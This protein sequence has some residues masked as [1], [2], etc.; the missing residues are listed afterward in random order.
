MIVY[1][2]DDIYINAMVGVT[3][4]IS[5]ISII[6]AIIIIS[7]TLYFGGRKSAML[8]NET[9]TKKDEYDVEVRIS[10]PNTYNS[11]D[12]DGAESSKLSEN[13]LSSMTTISIGYN[14]KIPTGFIFHENEVNSLGAYVYNKRLN[15]YKANLYSMYMGFRPAE[16]TAYHLFSAGEGCEMSLSDGL[17]AAYDNDECSYGIMSIDEKKID[18]YSNVATVTLMDCDSSIGYIYKN[19]KPAPAIDFIRRYNRRANIDGNLL[20]AQSGS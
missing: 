18:F 13:I 1:G 19:N 8:Q 6:V 5:V 2:Y 9:T 3:V 11:E 4:C 14:K 12:W 7:H 20:N 15:N 10:P 16:T 17:M